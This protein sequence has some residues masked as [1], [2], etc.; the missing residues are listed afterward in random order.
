MNQSKHR[1]PIHAQIFLCLDEDEMDTRE[2][3][4]RFKQLWAEDSYVEGILKQIRKEL[5]PEEFSPKWI[6]TLEVAETRWMIATE[7]IIEIDKDVFISVSWER[8]KTENQE[9]D[10]S[11]SEIVLVKPVEKVITTIDWVEVDA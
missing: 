10:F 7:E 8:G 1:C 4:Y 5:S 2:R 11:N 6:D 3:I 9:N